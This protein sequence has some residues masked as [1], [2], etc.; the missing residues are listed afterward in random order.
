MKMSVNEKDLELVSGG[1]QEEIDQIIA[2]FR[3]HGFEKEAKKLEKGGVYFF[4]DTFDAVMKDLGYT[5]QITTYADNENYNY[6][7]VNGER[8]G[9]MRFLDTL[10][11]FLYR[12]ANGIEWWQ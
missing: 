1:T 2:L 11:D 5:Q 7:I 6:N 4:K 9:Q 12:K 3:K 8:V 10:E